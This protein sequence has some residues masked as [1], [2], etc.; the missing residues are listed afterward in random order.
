MM[1]GGGS[2]VRY[3]RINF[4]L[5]IGLGK[6]GSWFPDELSA[7]L[8]HELQHAA[9]VAQWPDVVDNATLGAAYA[10]HDREQRGFRLESNAAR[11]AAEDRRAELRRERER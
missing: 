2:G 5:P 8:A 9:E 6:K 3:V 11:R 1:A 4:V 10:R 7:M